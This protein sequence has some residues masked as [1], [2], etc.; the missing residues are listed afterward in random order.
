M[1][2]GGFLGGQV[3]ARATTMEEGTNGFYTT[4]R[5]KDGGGGGSTLG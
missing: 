2:Q 3:V 4:G 1:L 5:E